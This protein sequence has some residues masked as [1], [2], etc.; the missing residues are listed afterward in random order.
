[1]S[2]LKQE[3][4][5]L[6]VNKERQD[7]GSFRTVTGTQTGAIIKSDPPVEIILVLDTYNAGPSEVAREREGIRTFLALRTRGTLRV[8]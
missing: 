8:P 1:M 3:D 2:G 7:I 4:F 5:I 6:K